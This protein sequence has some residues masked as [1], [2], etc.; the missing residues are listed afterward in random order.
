MS[1]W[2]PSWLIQPLP[3]TR[4]HV[5]SAYQ[6]TC[7]ECAFSV[8]LCGSKD[9]V[10]AFSKNSASGKGDTQTSQ[11]SMEQLRL[12]PECP[13]L[14]FFPLH[15][16]IR[17]AWGDWITHCFWKGDPCGCPICPQ[18]RIMR[19][20]IK[21][22]KQ[23]KNLFCLS[24]KLLNL[25]DGYTGFMI[26]F[27]LLLCIEFLNNTKTCFFYRM[28]RSRLSQTFSVLHQLPGHPS[29]AVPLITS[30]KPNSTVRQVSTSIQVLVMEGS[31]PLFSLQRLPSVGPKRQSHPFLGKE[32]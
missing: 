29:P 6:S 17:R 19:T 32:L 14:M 4:Q 12:K 1:G 10:Q 20:K 31:I 23:K 30:I 21:K 13:G 25:D 18:G 24:W 5:L 28:T 9:K 26:V 8:K 16:L 11:S 15:A 3:Y 2:N 7:V 22:K 27:F